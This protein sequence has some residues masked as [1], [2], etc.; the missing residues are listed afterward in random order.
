MSKNNNETTLHKLIGERLLISRRDMGW[1]QEDLGEK[2]GVSR[3]HIAKIERGEVSN[4][5][6]DVVCRLADALGIS[7]AYLLGFV[8]DPLFDGVAADDEVPRITRTQSTRYR[9]LGAELIDIF[10]QLSSESQQILL[11]I[12]DKLRDADDTERPRPREGEGL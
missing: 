12:A 4:P 10:G 3:G 11:A 7:R 9:T 8:D 5:T 1:K 6:I 2:S